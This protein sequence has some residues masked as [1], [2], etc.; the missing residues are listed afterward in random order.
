MTKRI[1]ALAVTV[2]F[3][4]GAFAPTA[5]LGQSDPYYGG[6]AP[7]TALSA[8]Q[9]KKNCKKKARKQA[10]KAPAGKKRSR[11]YKRSLKRCIKKA[12]R[13]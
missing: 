1:A 4:I 3:A 9:K 6:S 8:L 11:A 13:K 7:N 5:G 10:R 2:A 12:N